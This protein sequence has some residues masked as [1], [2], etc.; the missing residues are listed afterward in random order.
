VAQDKRFI[1]P[2][3]R[4]DKRLIPL[5][6]LAVLQF[7]KD[8]EFRR[9]LVQHKSQLVLYLYKDGDPQTALHNAARFRFADV[10]WDESWFRSAT[11][12]LPFGEIVNICY[13]SWMD[14]PIERKEWVGAIVDA[15]DLVSTVATA[16]VS[17]AA[18]GPLSISVQKVAQTTLTG[19]LKDS[20]KTVGR[21]Y[22]QEEDA[23]NSRT[24]VRVQSVTER[25]QG[26]GADG[27]QVSPAD[28]QL[29]DQVSLLQAMTA[30]HFGI[31]YKMPA[32]RKSE[33]VMGKQTVE[34]AIPSAPDELAEAVRTD[35]IS[36][37]LV[38]LAQY[39]ALP[40]DEQG[41]TAHAR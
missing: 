4:S 22:V 3:Q 5:G 8:T 30:E 9:L 14:Y 33:W 32:D 11:T 23:M 31:P 38:T 26:P 19:A 35:D 41:R 39:Q 20:L 40:K 6:A 29:Q 28:A 34:Y 2:N 13:K 17:Q 21:Q 27:E 37:L 25:K 24:Q 1:G 18:A 7:G 15:A 10:A 16:G 36:I 12:Y